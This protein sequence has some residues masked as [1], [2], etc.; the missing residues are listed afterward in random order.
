M[1]QPTLRLFRRFQSF[2]V[3]VCLGVALMSSST[4]LIGV[5]AVTSP[6][7]SGASVEGEVQAQATPGNRG[8]RGKGTAPKNSKPSEAA[9][10]EDE[11][12]K[13][14]EA[15]PEGET[16]D[17]TPTSKPT[18]YPTTRPGAAIEFTLK[19]L[20]GKDVP[21]SQFKGQLLLLVPVAWDSNR[22]QFSELQRIHAY[23]K[24]LGCLV[25]A[26]FTD[27]FAPEKRTDKELLK[28]IEDR[29]NVEFMFLARTHV[30]GENIH[31][32]FKYL[33]DPTESSWG[34]EIKGPFTKFLISRD[35]DYVG[36]WEPKERMLDRKTT[37]FM[38][39][40]FTKPMR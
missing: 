40:Y 10:K 32:L 23:A 19:D 39:D 34:R 15:K 26:V 3:A 17:A 33:S 28:A 4:G 9:P 24:D 11:P 8:D 2:V 30:K 38:T 22:R 13:D 18:T 27:D 37:E 35:G 12:K 7:G 20:D 21:L 5:W 1:H 14:D 31:P 36:R 16:D 25:I 6:D 29:Y